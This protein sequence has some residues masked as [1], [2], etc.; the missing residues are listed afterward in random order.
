LHFRVASLLDGARMELRKLK[1]RFTPLDAC[2]T[3]PLLRSDLEA[4]IVEIKDLKHKF[5]HSSRYTVLYPS[6]KA[7]VSFKVSFFMLPKGTPSFSKR[8]SI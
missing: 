8:L 2:T 3:C 5:D 7:C 6:C 1:T 4:S